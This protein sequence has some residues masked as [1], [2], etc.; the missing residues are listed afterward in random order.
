MR[1]PEHLVARRAR[2]APAARSA[3]RTCAWRRASSPT[4]RPHRAV[5]RSARVDGCGSLPSSSS[6]S[7]LASRRA[8]SIVTTATRLPSR[9]EPQRE[10]GGRRRLA[11]AARAGEDHDPLAVERSCE[12]PGELV[13]QRGEVGRRDGL[14]VQPQRRGGRS[15]SSGR[16][17]CARCLRARACAARA[18]WTP[19]P[20][21]WLLEPPRVGG[22]EAVGSQGVDHDRVELGVEAARAARP[23]ARASP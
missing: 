9:R 23:A 15:P 21:G 16:A 5:R 2:R 20:S 1:L 17:S 3:R 12:L 13:G 19:G 14:G 8:G 4:A 18:R 11:D 7:A 10:R 22:G 6:P